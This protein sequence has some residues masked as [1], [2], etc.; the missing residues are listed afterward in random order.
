MMRKIWSAATRPSPVVPKSRKIRCPLCSPPKLKPFLQHFINHVF[1][2]DGG[3]DHFSAGG[4]YRGFQSGVAHHGRDQGF[5]GQGFFRDHVKR[6]DGHDVV[7]VNQFSIFVAEQNAVGVAVVRD[8]DVRPC[9]ATLWHIC[10]GCM[11]PQSLL[12][13][14]PSGRWP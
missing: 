3:A 12:M 11:E 7:A 13:F 14:V 9:S 10:P 4:F 6:G 1:V 2:A 5:F 8:A